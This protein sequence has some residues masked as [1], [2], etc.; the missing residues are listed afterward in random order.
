MS[1]AQ[2]YSLFFIILSFKNTAS[3]L[4]A[5]QF[6]LI[7][8]CTSRAKVHLY[9]FWQCITLLTPLWIYLEG[10]VI[11]TW[12]F[13]HAFNLKGCYTHAHTHIHARINTLQNLYEVH[14]LTFIMSKLIIS[15]IQS[16]YTES[17]WGVRS[18]VRQWDTDINII[19]SWISMSSQFSKRYRSLH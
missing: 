19:L 15:V 9:S 11:K 12:W 1:L 16:M 10:K 17:P 3:L 7:S 6:P 8:N 2:E 14:V 18:C 5:I 13:S 4:I